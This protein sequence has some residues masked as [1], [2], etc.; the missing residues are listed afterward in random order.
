MKTVKLSSKGQVFIPKAIRKILHLQPGAELQIS[1]TPTGLT[2]TP[3][4]LFPKTTH[5][6]VCGVLTKAGSALPD[7]DEIKARIQARLQAKINASRS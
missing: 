7:D 6:Q 3:N 1:V 5:E 4:A 2:L